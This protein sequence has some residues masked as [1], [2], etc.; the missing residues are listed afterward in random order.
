MFKQMK[1]FKESHEKKDPRFRLSSDSD[2]KDSN[3]HGPRVSKCAA[4]KDPKSRLTS[5]CDFK[6]SN[7]PR[8]SKGAANKDLKARPTSDFKDSNGPRVSEGA[9]NI[10]FGTHQVPRL[11]LS[12]VAGRDR[13]LQAHPHRD[14]DDVS[15][16]HWHIQYPT[17][18]CIKTRPTNDYD[19]ES[20]EYPPYCPYENDWEDDV[21]DGHDDAEFDYHCETFYGKNPHTPESDND[22]PP[23]V[24]N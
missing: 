2:F 17:I 24:R 4:N 15:E 11:S 18:E 6:D 10:R 1:D 9:A 21:S 23:R 14:L 3:G 13:D 16:D 20:D 22:D 19:D 7:S 8:V 5:D 12:F